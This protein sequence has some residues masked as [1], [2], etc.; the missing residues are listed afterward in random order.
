MRR[1]EQGR[2]GRREKG[3]RKEEKGKD[4]GDNREREE[5]IL[6]EKWWEERSQVRREREG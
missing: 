6:R 1:E 4:E 2:V 5:I 3:V